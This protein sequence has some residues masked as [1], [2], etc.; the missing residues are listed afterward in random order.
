[1]NLIEKGKAMKAME[2]HTHKKASERVR[3]REG[4]AEERQRQ[5]DRQMD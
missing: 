3:E 5:E 1:M 2:R 4:G